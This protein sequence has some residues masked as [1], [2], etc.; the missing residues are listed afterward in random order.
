M[1]DKTDPKSDVNEIARLARL[2]SGVSLVKG[3]GNLLAIPEGME[4]VASDDIGRPF[5]RHTPSIGRLENLLTPQ[6]FV[7]FVLA[8]GSARTAVFVDFERGRSEAIL[9]YVPKPGTR[10]AEVEMPKEDEDENKAS[11]PEAYRFDWRA[12]HTLTPTSAWNALNA[13]TRLRPGSQDFA[14]SLVELRSNFAEPRR[15]R[16][17]D[18]DFGEQASDDLVAN[19]YGAQRILLDDVDAF[20]Q[21]KGAV[22]GPSIIQ[23]N[24]PVFEGA[25]ISEVEMLVSPP[26]SKSSTSGTVSIIGAEKLEAEARLSTITK[27]KSGLSGTYSV[28]D[29][30]LVFND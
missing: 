6:S 23:F 8:Y 4:V 14:I 17:F 11:R 3:A 27:L 12:R 20:L 10:P 19:V 24:I 22:E 9:N 18:T 15:T 5:L 26:K 16:I 2:A 1:T 7:D 13:L 21:N 30:D 25:P 28:F 29:A